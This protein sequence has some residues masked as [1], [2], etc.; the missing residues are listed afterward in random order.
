MRINKLYIKIFLCNLLVILGLI[1]AIILVNTVMNV[2]EYEPREWIIWLS[3]GI[4]GLIGISYLIM[5][6]EQRY[7]Y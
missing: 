4:S 7:E 1:P 6:N 3:I 2:G 5:K